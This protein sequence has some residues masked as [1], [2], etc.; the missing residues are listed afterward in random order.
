MFECEY[1]SSEK[2]LEVQSQHALLLLPRVGV[3]RGGAV[4]VAVA[5]LPLA[6]KQVHVAVYQNRS[7]GPARPQ[8]GALSGHTVLRWVLNPESAGKMEA[9]HQRSVSEGNPAADRT[10]IEMDGEQQCVRPPRGVER[11]LEN[12]PASTHHTADGSTA[13]NKNKQ[14]D[15]IRYRN[16]Y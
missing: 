15:N 8:Q 5:V 11:R 12:T 4:L 7:A 13:K 3:E 14:T 10:V 6:G 16:Q 2:V 1:P 9:P